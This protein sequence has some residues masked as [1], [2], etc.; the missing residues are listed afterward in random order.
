MPG[1]IFQWP[2]PATASEI[3]AQMAGEVG[4]VEEEETTSA[5][6]MP[7]NYLRQNGCHSV[8]YYSTT[9]VLETIA[10]P[11]PSGVYLCRSSSHATLSSPRLLRLVGLFCSPLTCLAVG[12]RQCT[13]DASANAAGL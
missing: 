1:T 8:L 11:L 10:P 5:L 7:H 4:P 12:R 13:L 3:L 2:S 6:Q 9:T